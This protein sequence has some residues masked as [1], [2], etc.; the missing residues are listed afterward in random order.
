MVPSEAK[1][2]VMVVPIFSPRTRAAAV[3]KP[4]IPVPARAIVIPTVA[5]EDWTMAVTAAPTRIHLTIPQ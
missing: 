2:G 3:W 4:I 1:S 5:D